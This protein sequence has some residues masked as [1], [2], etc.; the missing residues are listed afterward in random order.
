MLEFE[1]IVQMFKSPTRW[2]LKIYCACLRNGND[3]GTTWPYIL[4]VSKIIDVKSCSDK[5]I[6]T[7]C[8]QLLLESSIGK[9]YLQVLQKQVIRALH[10]LYDDEIVYLQ[11]N[12]VPPH[13]HRDVRGWIYWFQ[14]SSAVDRV[15]R[16][17]F[18]VSVAI[19]RLKTH[20]IHIWA[21]GLIDFGFF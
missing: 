10:N 11:Q 20:R 6:C 8:A 9:A 18:G 14:L 2:D 16:R 13:S 17:H 12:R 7:H 21:M 5:H 3:G 1:S 4:A 19:F 15:K